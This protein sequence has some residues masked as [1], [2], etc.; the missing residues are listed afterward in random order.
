MMA[1]FSFDSSARFKY[2]LVEPGTS[3]VRSTVDQ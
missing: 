1:Q 2:Y 3:W